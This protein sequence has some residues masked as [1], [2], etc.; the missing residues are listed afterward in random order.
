MKKINKLK[1]RLDTRKWI[2]V[3]LTVILLIVFDQIFKEVAIATLK[4][5]P[6][7]SF[8]GDTFRLQYAENKGAFLSLGSGLSDQSRFW[9]LGVIVLAFLSIY[10]SQVLRGTPNRIVIYGISFVLGGGV[11][12]LLDRFFRDQGSVIDFM[13]LG[14]GNL[15]TGIFNIADMAIV[16]GVSLLFFDS[17]LSKRS[18]KN[19]SRQLNE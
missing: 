1:S 9:V 13:N 14:F 10:A 4:G 3:I 16:V 7:I 5:H 18:A 17:W 2:R 8:L 6:T 19:V 12:N 11:S 15:R